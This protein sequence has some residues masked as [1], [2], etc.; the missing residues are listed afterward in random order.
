MFCGLD[1]CHYFKKNLLLLAVS[2]PSPSIDVESLYTNIDTETDL[3]VVENIFLQYPD[4]QIC[5]THNDFEFG[6]ELFL[7]IRGTAMKW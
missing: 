4:R 6:G 5:L 1:Y 3:R 7:Q 2:L